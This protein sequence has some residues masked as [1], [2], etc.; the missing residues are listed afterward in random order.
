M[1]KLLQDSEEYLKYINRFRVKELK[2]LLEAA[3]LTKSGYKSTL[4][5]RCK[6]IPLDERIQLIVKTLFA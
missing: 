1:T 6:T 4:I 2:D 3:R 5:E